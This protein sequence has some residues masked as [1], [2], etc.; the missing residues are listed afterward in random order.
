MN[1]WS[2]STLDLV[3]NEDY[4]DRL[5]T[6]YTH[7]DGVR[8]VPKKVITAIRE[9]FE[10]KDETTLI[11]QLLDLGKFPY[12][13]SYV[14]FLRRDRT[15][16]ERNPDT[17]KRI[18]DRIFDMGIDG[19]VAGIM[20]P[21]EANTRRGNQFSNWLKAQYQP[22]GIDAFMKSKEGIVMLEAT[23]LEAKDF[24]NRHLHVGIT[25]RPD[26]VVKV[27]KRYVI[28]EA[29][30]LSSAGGNHDRAF[31]DGIKLATNSDGSAYKIFV[32]DGIFWI[33]QGSDQ[34]HRIDHSTASI[35]S[36]LL[37]DDFL[38]SL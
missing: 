16:I 8:T 9:S 22:L 18:C 1:S 10:K 30:F 21:K 6:I 17:V 25:K 31:D 12:K 37:L 7:E 35:F 23:E 33:E 27:G 32:L 29:K 28:G 15:A 26:V 34:F 5:Q 24:C 19:L 4:L 38:N 13:D 3:C 2:K 11:N 36:A 14:A 20:Q